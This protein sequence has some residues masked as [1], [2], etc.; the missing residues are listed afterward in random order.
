MQYADHFF[1]A[2]D[3]ALKGIPKLQKK[4]ETTLA[5]AT[6]AANKHDIAA[7]ELNKADRDLKV[8]WMQ[9]ILY[10]PNS[11]DIC[12]TLLQFKQN[13]SQRVHEEFQTKKARAEEM[14]RQKQAHEV[15]WSYCCQLFQCLRAFGTHRQSARTGSTIF[16]RVS[17]QTSL[18]NKL[19]T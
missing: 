14:M 19:T 2:T 8:G 3:K 9:R 7:I 4:E 15:C 16:I 17:A 12:A 5:A 18:R 6:K 10:Q 11:D 13:Q 1:Q